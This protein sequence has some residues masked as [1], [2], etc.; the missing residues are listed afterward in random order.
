MAGAKG[1]S[2]MRT[3]LTSRN[4][5]VELLRGVTLFSSCSGRELEKI[6]SLTT[7]Y[8]AQVGQVLTEEGTA[9][10]E[11]F[12]VIEGEAVASRRGVFLASLGPGSFFGELALLDGG[13]RVATVVAE[14]DMKVLVLSRQEFKNLNFMLPSVCHKMLLELGARLRD[15]D[16]RLSRMASER[17]AVVAGDYGS[18]SL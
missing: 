14:T 11:F 15:T 5:R 18:S 17:P 13:P 8:A 2:A 7:E 4:Q 9:G 6:A 12:V 10:L 1:R 16:E 3:K